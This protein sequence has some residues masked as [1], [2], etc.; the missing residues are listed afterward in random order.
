MSNGNSDTF[1]STTV[2]KTGRT[3]QIYLAQSL[4]GNNIVFPYFLKKYAELIE[5][6]FSNPVLLGS[7]KTK[8][9]YATVDNQIVAALVFE[10]HEDIG[11]T[12]WVL[13]SVVNP[14]LRKNGIFKI[15]HGC[16]EEFSKSAGSKKIASFVHIDNKEMLAS[17]KSVGREL[18]FYRTEKK[19]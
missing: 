6:G 5:R 9:I 15:L 19:L 12:T 13:L 8:A 14:E 16:L 11:K 3:I 1:I 4:N 2:D 10:M 17:C 18:V 7:A